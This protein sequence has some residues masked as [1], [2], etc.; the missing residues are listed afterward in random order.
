[1]AHLQQLAQAGAAGMVHPKT[2]SIPLSR[3][4]LHRA[5]LGVPSDDAAAAA[6]GCYASS[7]NRSLSS[8][9]TAWCCELMTHQEGK[10]L[11]ETAGD[12]STEESDALIQTL[13]A[14]LGSDTRRWVTGEGPHHLLIA[15]DPSLQ[16]DRP[17]TLRS[18]EQLIEQPWNRHLPKGTVGE[19]LRRLI[20]ET[21]HVLED[22]PV[23]R[24]RI[25]LGEN[26]ANLVWYWGAANGEADRTPSETVSRGIIVSSQFPMRGLAQVLGLEWKEG[27][28]SFEERALQ[29][30]GKMLTEC[31]SN[32]EVIYVHFRIRSADPVERLCAMER[33]DQ[34]ILHPLTEHLH[35]LDSW[36]F[37][38]AIDDHVHRAVS[39][40]ALGSGLPRQPVAQLNA[41]QFGASPL[42]FHD[43]VELC[44]WL[45][46]S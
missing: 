23:N 19:A 45:T 35:R 43:G 25:D 21:S 4:A 30:A 7:M 17:L 41:E 1:M 26:P 33:I 24:V 22:H 11:D 16:S 18:P 38:A 14:Q 34:L 37:L 40:V 31:L 46:Q 42:V 44:A 9:E 15:R 10:I 5:L 3:F 27:A 39:F 32:H 12:I 2:S 13:N 28:A 20:E 29:R 8:G 6:A 36:R